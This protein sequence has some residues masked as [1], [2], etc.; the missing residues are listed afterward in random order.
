MVDELAAA[1]AA[2]ISA[3]SAAQIRGRTRARLAAR[4]HA[5]DVVRAVALEHG[6][7]I[8]PVQLRKISLDTSKVEQVMIPCGTTMASICPPCAERAK[9]L[10]AAQCCEGWHLEDEPAEDARLPDDHQRW[11]VGTW[12]DLQVQRERAAANGVETSELGDFIEVVEQQLAA[13]GVRGHLDASADSA[14]ES[15]QGDRI[16][17]SRRHR[18]TRRR[19]DAPGLPK[20]KVSRSTV[21]RVYRA[22]DG[23]LH[24]PSMFVT[25]TCPSYGRVRDDSTP[26]DPAT[27]D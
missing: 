3:G 22:P 1:S 4:P 18:S 21:G 20:R 7:C 9:V 26:V 8:R 12:A 2:E 10:R 16:L 24:R 15:R 27:Y 19:Q 25:L 14:R 17:R 6:A 5:R 11:L 13:T 23:K